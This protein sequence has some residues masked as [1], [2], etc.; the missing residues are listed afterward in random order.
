MK[1][2]ILIT[3]LIGMLLFASCTTVQDTS[4]TQVADDSIVVSETMPA[5]DSADIEEILVEETAEETEE[6]VEDTTEAVADTS[7][8]ETTTE[9]N[10]K[11]IEIEAFNWGFEV[12]SADEIHTG[13]SVEMTIT[14]SAG[15]HGLSFDDLDIAT[16]S[17]R[18]GN[19]ETLTFIAPAAGEY[20]YFCSVMC[21]SGHRDME[22]VLVVLE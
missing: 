2:Y 9:S 18:S 13:D 12:I 15:T 4:D 17:I 8:L 6:V 14:S 11:I 20:G 5:Q 1:K 10:I 21:G 19:S 22:G 3:M 7:D 16:S